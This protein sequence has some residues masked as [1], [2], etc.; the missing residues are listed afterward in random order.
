MCSIKSST[1]VLYPHSLSYQVTNFMK[2]LASPIPAL[3]SNMLDLEVKKP[4][5]QHQ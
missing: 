5:D 2:E 3:A 1:R 4:S